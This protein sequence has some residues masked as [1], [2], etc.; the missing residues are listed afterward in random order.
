M[1]DWA[2]FVPHEP[3]DRIAMNFNKR[4]SLKNVLIYKLFIE[5]WA[6]FLATFLFDEVLNSINPWL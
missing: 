1:G 3:H 6:I 4:I 5:K 2:Y